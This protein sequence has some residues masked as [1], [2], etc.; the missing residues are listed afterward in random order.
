MCANPNWSHPMQIQDLKV[1]FEG[2]ILDFE[3]FNKKQEKTVKRATKKTRNVITNLTII[4]TPDKTIIKVD[5]YSTLVRYSAWALLSFN[6][7]TYY[8]NDFAFRSND[9]HGNFNIFWCCFPWSW[10]NEKVAINNNY[11]GLECISWISITK[12]VD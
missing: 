1:R 12:L 10:K 11:M 9:T 2:W 3:R 4:L 7:A 6:S 5:G 8:L